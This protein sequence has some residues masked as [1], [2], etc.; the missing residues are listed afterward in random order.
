MRAVEK[1]LTAVWIIQPTLKSSLRS[2]NDSDLINEAIALTNALPGSK[3][4]GST[5]VKIEKLST[6][7]FFGKACMAKLKVHLETHGERKR[8]CCELCNK[9][10]K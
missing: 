3:I 1:K 10:F 7:E 5:T 6:R 9:S 2:K 8:V 4:I